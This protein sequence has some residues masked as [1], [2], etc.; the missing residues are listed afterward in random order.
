MKPP[1]VV[2]LIG[3][4]LTVAVLAIYLI[5]ITLILRH[6]NFTLGTIIAAIRAIANQCQPLG[7]VMNDINNDLGSVRATFEGVAQQATMAQTGGRRRKATRGRSAAQSERESA[8][9]G[10]D[11]PTEAG[12]P[13]PGH[14]Q[15]ATSQARGRG[16]KGRSAGLA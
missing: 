7:A 4:A 1:A 12:M 2:T 8:G 15:T 9:P 10:R 5:R 14:T 6:V 3:V 13:A 11:M 16:R